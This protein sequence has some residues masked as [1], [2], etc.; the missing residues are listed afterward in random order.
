MLHTA[1][2]SGP[3]GRTPQKPDATDRTGPEA[4]ST[5]VAPTGTGTGRPVQHATGSVR[6]SSSS[7]GCRSER[8]I[9]VGS[10]V[11]S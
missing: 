9:M 5:N 3:T 1:C 2:H 4:S 7:S 10:S 6:S 11:S 8:K